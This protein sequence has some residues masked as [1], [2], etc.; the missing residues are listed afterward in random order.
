MSFAGFFKNYLFL[1]IFAALGL[2]CFAWAFSSCSEWGLL[3][4]R[5]HYCGTWA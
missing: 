4:L 2:H 3:L 1:L 5:A